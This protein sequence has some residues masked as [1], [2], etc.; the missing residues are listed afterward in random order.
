[1]TETQKVAAGWLANEILEAIR[2]ESDNYDAWTGIGIATN[3]IGALG[4][5]AGPSAS[6]SELVAVVREAYE[7]QGVK[8]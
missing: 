4:D 7:K 5:L 6:T 3:M 1:M 8:T 2:F